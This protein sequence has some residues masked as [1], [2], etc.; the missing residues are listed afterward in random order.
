MELSNVIWT[1]FKTIPIEYWDAVSESGDLIN[2]VKEGAKPT[3]N[4]LKQL[5]DVWLSL[6]DQY[7]EEF[8]VKPETERRL[9]TLEKLVKLNKEFVKSRD[10]NILNFIEIEEEKLTV[11]GKKVKFYQILNAVEKYKGFQ[12][13]P[14]EYPSIKWFY[15]LEEMSKKVDNE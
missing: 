1:S 14:K 11:K 12:I 10:R 2:L 4:E 3:A 13:N 7:F 9:K 15:A 5:N 8:G 6:Q